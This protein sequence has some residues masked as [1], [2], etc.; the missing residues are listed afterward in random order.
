VR[1]VVISSIHIILKINKKITQKNGEMKQKFYALHIFAKKLFDK[2]IRRT[3]SVFI[4]LIVNSV[5]LTHAI[6]PHHHH[7]SLV[8]F[9]NSHCSTE[10]E[11]HEHDTQKHEHNHDSNSDHCVL[12]Q[13]FIIPSQHLSQVSKCA[14]SGNNHVDFQ[15]TLLF[16][17]TNFGFILSHGLFTYKPFLDSDYSRLINRRLGLR[18]P[19]LV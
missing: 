12:K 15:A 17:T 14:D 7:F 11:K 16:S 18:A 13:A 3:T 2:M 1:N 19:P 8:C 4:F 6:I 5:L 9:E 10:T